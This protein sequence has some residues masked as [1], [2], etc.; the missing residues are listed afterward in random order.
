MI[1][2]QNPQ[3]VFHQSRKQFGNYQNSSPTTFGHQSFTGEVKCWV[4]VTRWQDSCGPFRCLSEFIIK[5][6]TNDESIHISHLFLFMLALISSVV[7]IFMQ[8]FVAHSEA[9][10]GMA[11][12]GRGRT[13]FLPIFPQ[14]KAR[15]SRDSS[16]KMISVNVLQNTSRNIM[17]IF[18]CNNF[19]FFLIFFS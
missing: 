16:K 14:S 6:S 7:T 8:N 13:V 3:C 10:I 2:R 11:H 1:F 5:A 19:S 4:A 17:L 12:E 9:T 15:P 18:L